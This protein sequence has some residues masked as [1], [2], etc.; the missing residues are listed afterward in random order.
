MTTMLE[1]KVYPEYTLGEKL[2]KVYDDEITIL[3][4]IE[5]EE[6]NR[7]KTNSEGTTEKV[8]K[9]Y[10]LS[11]LSLLHPNNLIKRS[12]LDFNSAKAQAIKNID[13][14]IEQAEVEI[15]YQQGI[16]KSLKEKKKQYEEMVE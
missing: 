15:E 13:S 10:R 11:D 12:F 16:I 3:Q 6:L 1:K 5:I 7:K 14:L 4:V 9:S 8:E 2:Y